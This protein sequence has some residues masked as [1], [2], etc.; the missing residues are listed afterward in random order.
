MTQGSLRTEYEAIADLGEKIGIPNLSMQDFDLVFAAAEGVEKY[1][2]QFEAI[3]LTPPERFHFM[4][5]IV[6]SLDLALERGAQGCKASEQ[7]VEALL[8]N[9]LAGYRNIID[10]W[11]DTDSSWRV[12]PLMTRLKR[13][14]RYAHAVDAAP[15]EGSQS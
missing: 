6:A 1:C 2:D 7:R 5:L 13:N 12:V 3:E 9:D 4:Q 14:P 11:G 10:Y 15:F 8:L